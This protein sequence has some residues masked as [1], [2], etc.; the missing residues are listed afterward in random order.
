MDGK[1]SISLVHKCTLLSILEE[2]DIIL[3]LS[4]FQAVLCE[5]EIFCKEV[6][7]LLLAASL[8][9]QSNLLIRVIRVICL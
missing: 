5:K 3:P 7:K 2:S 4:K 9:S 8:S 6:G 1:Q